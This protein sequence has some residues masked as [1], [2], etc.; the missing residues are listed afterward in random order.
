MALPALK[1]AVDLFSA[2]T[3]LLTGVPEA[4][5]EFVDLAKDQ[6]E[7][8]ARMIRDRKVR[9]ALQKTNISASFKDLAAEGPSSIA[10][11][12]AQ[13]NATISDFDKMIARGRKD[14]AEQEA[15][16]DLEM[17]RLA[18]HAVETV[19][20]TRK[21]INRF[22]KL[23]GEFHNET[24]EFYYFLLALRADYDP[25]AK[26]GPSFKDRRTLVAYLHEQTKA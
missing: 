14:I 8:L 11:G 20:R 12:L 23:A 10:A 9:A 18:P 1:S 22:F 19:R 4:E 15:A 26:G 3:P 16:F 21:Q 7:K 25:E 17:A 24:V 13:L 2:Q 5:R 6:I